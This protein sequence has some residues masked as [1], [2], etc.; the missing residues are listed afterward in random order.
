MSAADISNSFL[1][2][3][4]Q[5]A[6]PVEQVVESDD[7][8]TDGAES[9]QPA[10]RDEHLREGGAGIACLKSICVLVCEPAI[11]GGVSVPSPSCC[12]T[13]ALK[14]ADILSLLVSIYGRWWRNL[15]QTFNLHNNEFMD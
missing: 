4:R 7:D 6:K 10:R 9:W 11:N 15:L 13:V 14:S 5:G 12:T 2:F 8:E 1:E 3:R